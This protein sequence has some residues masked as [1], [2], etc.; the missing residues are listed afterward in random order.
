M[1]IASLMQNLLQV[2]KRGLIKL[3]VAEVLGTWHC[4][5]KSNA[6]MYIPT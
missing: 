3:Q 5:A 6:G 4:T 1:R 2:K